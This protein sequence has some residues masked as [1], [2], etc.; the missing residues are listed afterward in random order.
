MRA[1][2]Q[3]LLPAEP[4]Q[5]VVAGSGVF[6]SPET[7]AAA[8]RL[9]PLVSEARRLLGRGMPSSQQGPTLESTG[10]KLVDAIRITL[11]L[12]PFIDMQELA[13]V[14]AHGRLQEAVGQFN[15][16]VSASTIRHRQEIPISVSDD[17]ASLTNH[18]S[19]SVQLSKQFRTGLTVTP[20][21]SLTRTAETTLPPSVA[22][23]LEQMPNQS[24]LSVSLT[25][26]L[27][28]GRGR[29]VVG[30]IERINEIELEAADQDLIQMRSER[31]LVS[32]VSYWEYLAALRTLEILQS[33][34]SR[35]RGLL[36]RTQE[37][38]NGGNRPASD[39]TQAQANLS[40]H[41]SQRLAAEQN[42]FAAGHVLALAL[43]LT[44]NDV[45]M[46]PPP[47]DDFPPITDG[48]APSSA[49][50]IQ[51]ALNRRSDI[52][53]ARNRLRQDQVGLTAAQ[54]ALRPRLDLSASAGY[55]GLDVGSSFDKFLTPFW[56]SVSG[57]NASVSLTLDLPVGND[58]AIGQFIQSRSALSQ[59]TVG[60]TD[61]E[62]TIRSNVLVARNHLIRSA[63]RIRSAQ[64]AAELYRTA[65]ID[66][67]LRQELGLS[68]VI[69]LIVT[70]ERLTESLLE[71]ISARL[72]YASAIASLRY[73]TGSLVRPGPA[74]EA[75]DLRWLT[76]VP[77][78]GV[79]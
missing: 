24:N 32:L 9:T 38:I 70:E 54:N 65:I 16:T 29:E 79:Q 20:G 26:P 46:P 64:A 48:E 59:R 6:G 41:I 37:L 72:S 39:L 2:E 40:G 18:T 61:L 45:N 28:R 69:D 50:L 30:A 19:Y 10:L 63:A 3:L 51:E 7:N 68:T 11:E 66:E 22:S 44:T 60:L 55:S 13:V 12:H 43:G 1:N 27:L 47:I 14:D 15:T 49:A 34:E 36:D 33:S 31:A 57:P 74:A 76:T 21:V 71:E 23:L 73:E 62:R 67:Q 53:A 52:A 35:S 56:A 78:P 17:L 25:Q 75:V 77:R 42:L 8:T 58:A 5:E 4:S